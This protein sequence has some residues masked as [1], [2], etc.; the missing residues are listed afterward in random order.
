MK[1]WGILRISNELLND[2]FHK[3]MEELGFTLILLEESNMWHPN[4]SVFAFSH[5]DCDY[6]AYYDP[7]FTDKDGKLVFLKFV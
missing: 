2:E 1:H 3:K 4:D 5:A 7:L 6:R